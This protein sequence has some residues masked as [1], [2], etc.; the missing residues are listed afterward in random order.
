MI[1]ARISRRPLFSAVFILLAASIV[2][3]SCLS[4][5][6]DLLD[7]LDSPA[8]DAI[9]GTIQ[10]VDEASEE[11]TPENE[12]YIGRSVAAAITTQYAVCKNAPQM[13]AYLNAI[14]GAITMNSSMPYLYKGY[15][16]AVLDTDEINAMATPGGH[17]FVSRGLIDSCTSEDELAAVIAH[18]VAHIQLRHSISAIKTSRIT[19]AVAQGVKAT[20]MVGVF[21][22]NKK[23]EEKKGWGL[24]D[25]DMAQVLE[26][27]AS[28]SDIT[29]EIAEKLVN[30]G[31]SKSQEFDAD[32][33]ALSLM[34]DAGYNPVA[35]IEMLEK[36]PTGGNH[37][38]DATHPDP[39][40]RIKK[41]QSALMDMQ[42]EAA[43]PAVSA[44]ARALRGARFKAN[45]MN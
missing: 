42:E 28:F 11:I 20:A 19:G 2:F 25:E 5:P 16:V 10:A 29:N 24:S 7:L 32:E 37:G 39:E 30:S 17:I 41:V 12:Y 8:G 35:M 36:I 27:T 26:A 34:A 44:E 21:A 40:I 31:F 3:T 38:W 43:L 6:E 9:I 22:A 45:R 14:C 23:L 1:F 4:S 33:T 15:C 13:T 18:E